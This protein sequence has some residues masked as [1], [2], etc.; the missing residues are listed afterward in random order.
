M[1]A[2]F[3]RE[4]R[5]RGRSRQFTLPWDPTGAGRGGAGGGEGAAAV[6]TFGKVISEYRL[7][8]PGCRV[9]P[10]FNLD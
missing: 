2:S 4:H 7:I 1:N 3:A 10:E 9:L 6:A 5:R 8:R